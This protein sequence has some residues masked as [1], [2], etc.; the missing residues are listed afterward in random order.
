MSVD[1]CSKCHPYWTG[2]LKQNTTGG[3][4]DKFKKKY[5]IAFRDYL[6]NL[7]IEKAQEL[8]LHT[9]LRIY[10]IAQQVGFGKA[11]YFINKFVQAN[12]MTPNQYRIRNRKQGKEENL[13]NTGKRG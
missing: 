12:Q 9:N 10:A 6:N 2:N 8:L 11:E 5:G 4:A 7:R 3:R 13:Q 1:V